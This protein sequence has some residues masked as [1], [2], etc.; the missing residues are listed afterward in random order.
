MKIKSVASDHT[1]QRTVVG[2]GITKR[3]QDLRQAIPLTLG[4]K[5]PRFFLG[6][7]F[8][9]TPDHVHEHLMVESSVFTV[10]LTEDP[11]RPLF[12]YDYERD[13]GDGYPEAHLQICASSPDWDQAGIRLDGSGRLLEKLHLP[14]GGRRFRP[15]VE[16]I[17]EFLVCEQLAEGRPGWRTAVEEGRQ[18]FQEKQ[19]RAAVRKHPDV[20][21]AALEESHR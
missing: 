5:A 18:R 8:R 2:Y 13:K 16:D 17:I 15:A 12:H 19:L 1:R 10:S 21:R 11:S 14:V 6:L 9:L 3:E 20:A 4:K 7:H